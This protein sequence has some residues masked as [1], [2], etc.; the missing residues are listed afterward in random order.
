MKI[1]ATQPSPDKASGPLWLVVDLFSGSWFSKVKGPSA[2]RTSLCVLISGPR[3][4]R[5]SE[6]ILTLGQAA[7]YCRVSRTTIKRLVAERILAKQQLLP[8]APWEIQRQELEAEPV[9]SIL[10]HLR[11]T[12][13]LVLGGVD[14][15]NQE[16]LFQ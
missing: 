6:D 3:H 10:Q 7:A 14:L 5:V 13:K 8:W 11:E 4:N 2:A 16:S 9:Q 12:G 15:V 1:C